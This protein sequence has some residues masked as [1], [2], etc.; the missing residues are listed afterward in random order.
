MLRIVWGFS[1]G[2]LA[3]VLFDASL[4]TQGLSF[5][6][7]P[8]TQYKVNARAR[9]QST[10]SKIHQI[11]TSN[12][13]KYGPVSSSSVSFRMHASDNQGATDAPSSSE[14]SSSATTVS[15]SSKLLEL[16]TGAGATGGGQ[17]HNGREELHLRG[18]TRKFSDPQMWTH[19]FFVAAAIPSYVNHVF[20]LFM[21]LAT[22]T[23]LS[24][25]YHY[26]YE[27]PGLLA[28]IEGTF[29]K[30]LF[31]YGAIQMFHAPSKMLLLVETGFLLATIAIFVFTNI[32]PR[33]YDPWHCLLHIVPSLWCMVVGYNHKP[34]VF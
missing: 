8:S 29:A 13:F 14:F 3:V 19:L 9:W 30:F 31:I 32:K 25:A 16:F 4:F 21:L 15:T 11:C 6:I 10:G 18:V 23:P 33:F 1:I 5:G 28:Q 12:R 2:Y 7:M 17:M 27:K 34:L 26:V 22:V 20:D 24:L